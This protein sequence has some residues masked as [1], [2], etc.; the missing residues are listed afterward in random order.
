MRPPLPVM[1]VVT[2][3][4]APAR[5]RAGVRSRASLMRAPVVSRVAMSAAMRGECASAAVMSAAAPWAS[6]PSRRASSRPR[7]RGAAPTDSSGTATST[8]SSRSQT[9]KLRM[10]A[11][12]RTWVEV[13]RCEIEARYAVRS[14]PD[15]VRGSMPLSVH[16]RSHERTSAR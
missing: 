5:S 3:P 10:P 2:R 4:P 6:R 12:R 16:Q 7:V 1:V 9:W 13:A 14:R 11:R 8:P 15:A